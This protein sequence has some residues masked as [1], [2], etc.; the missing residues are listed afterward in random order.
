[1]FLWE[2]FIDVEY[3]LE[4]GIRAEISRSKVIK[5]ASSEVSFKL[6]KI[7]SNVWNLWK[8]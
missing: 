5:F 3:E 6:V 1:M 8:N 7:N 2:E 4:K